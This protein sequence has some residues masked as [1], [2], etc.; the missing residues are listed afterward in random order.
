MHS[1]MELLPRVLFGHDRRGREGPGNPRMC[2]SCSS[3]ARTTAKKEEPQSRRGLLT[4][5]PRGNRLQIAQCP[6][7]RTSY[8]SCSCRGRRRGGQGKSIK[9]PPQ[10]RPCFSNNKGSSPPTVPFQEQPCS[11]PEGGVE[12]SARKPSTVGTDQQNPALLHVIPLCHLCQLCS[13]LGSTRETEAVCL[14][15]KCQPGPNSNHIA[16]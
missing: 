6:L 13:Q 5:N 3:L 2:P 15:Q 7:P 12:Y 14:N 4:W 1:L 10:V 8:L 9:N 16:C 11:G